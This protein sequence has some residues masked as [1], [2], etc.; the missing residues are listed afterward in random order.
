MS[1]HSEYC[2][3]PRNSLCFVSFRTTPDRPGRSRAGSPRTTAD[4]DLASAH[5]TGEGVPRAAVALAVVAIAATT[6]AMTATAVL[7]GRLCH[8]DHFQSV[9]PTTWLAVET[10]NY[11]YILTILFQEVCF[12][13]EYAFE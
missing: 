10:G 7:V 4:A 5:H 8:P 2:G 9:L 12:K 13:I 1:S 11:L 3:R 6:G